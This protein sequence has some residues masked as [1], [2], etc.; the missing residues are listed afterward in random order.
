[1]EDG[2]Q[3][4]EYYGPYPGLLTSV[5][6]PQ[7]PSAYLQ[8]RPSGLHVEEPTAHPWACE[9]SVFYQVLTSHLPAP[10]WASSHCFRP[11]A[12]SSPPILGMRS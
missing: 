3:D 10:A 1:M 8:K 5:K 9:C 4:P 2:G 12:P 7:Q 6:L 11:P